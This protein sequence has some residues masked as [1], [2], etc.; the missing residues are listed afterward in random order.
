MEKWSRS[1]KLALFLFALGIVLAPLL[2]ILANRLDERIDSWSEAL[3]WILFLVCLGFAVFYL[4]QSRRY[5]NMCAQAEADKLLLKDSLPADWEKIDE[6]TGLLG[7]VK[8]LEGSDFHPRACLPNIVSHLDFMGHG[9]SKWT[10][11]SDL[12]EEMLGKTKAKDGKVRFLVRNPIKKAGSNDDE[13]VQYAEDAERI[14][15]S[16]MIL[17]YLHRKYT[18]LEIRVY[19]HPPQFR[20]MFLDGH[21]LVVGHYKGYQRGDSKDTPLQI[22]EKKP[23]WS[24]YQ[25]YRSHFATEWKDAHDVDWEAVRHLA[26]TGE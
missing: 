23:Q 26:E 1:D 7:Y 4:F 8:K 25:A 12:L 22:Y 19:D 3:P 24:F 2:S 21:I 17:L 18:H 5:K 11:N 14:A 10:S 20:L 16:L 15:Q 13:D 6:Y 9:A